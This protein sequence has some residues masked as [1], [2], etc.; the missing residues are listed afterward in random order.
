MKN[1]GKYRLFKKFSKFKEAPPHQRWEYHIRTQLD[2]YYGLSHNSIEWCLHFSTLRWVQVW[3]QCIFYRWNPSPTDRNYSVPN[4]RL[5]GQYWEPTQKC[6]QWR[7]V[8]EVIVMF[9]NMSSTF[10][11]FVHSVTN[12]CALFAV[13]THGRVSFFMWLSELRPSVQIAESFGNTFKQKP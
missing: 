10:I 12:F 11:R 3:N 5:D 9:A 1:W 4:H 6:F 13:E 7:I 8:V 2:E